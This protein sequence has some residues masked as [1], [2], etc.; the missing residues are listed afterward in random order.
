MYPIPKVF[1]RWNPLLPGLK[2]RRPGMLLGA[3][4]RFV[5]H[6]TPQAPLGEELGHPKFFLFP[7]CHVL[8]IPCNALKWRIPVLVVLRGAPGVK[9]TEPNK[10]RR[11]RIKACPHPRF[12]SGPLLSS[13]RG[14]PALSE[15]S[16]SCYCWL[17]TKSTLLLT[18]YIKWAGKQLN[19]WPCVAFSPGFVG[20]HKEA[21]ILHAALDGVWNWAGTLF[22]VHTLNPIVC[23][24]C[25]SALMPNTGGLWVI[26]SIFILF[27]FKLLGHT[28]LGVP[29]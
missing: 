22:G 14:A 24:Q 26:F 13:T 27:F 17:G 20:L 3:D 10:R 5:F 8:E 1:G 23:V 19:C 25:S 29:G 15:T 21:N 2:P 7:H 11:G 16:C 9:H 18:S 12:I 4:G 6:P 28:Q